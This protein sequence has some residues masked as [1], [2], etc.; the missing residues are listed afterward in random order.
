MVLQWLA[1]RPGLHYTSRVGARDSPD[2]VEVLPF[3]QVF[4][5]PVVRDLHLTRSVTGLLVALPQKILL[6]EAVWPC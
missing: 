1:C 2:R 6:A 3:W 4:T 5:T